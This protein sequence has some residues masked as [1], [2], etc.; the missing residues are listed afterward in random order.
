MPRP[1]VLP[2][3]LAAAIPIFAATATSAATRNEAVLAE[4]NFARMHPAQYG[5]ELEHAALRGG[6]E[7]L[8]EIGNEDVGAL[9]HALAF[10]ERQRPLPPLEESA[11][12]DAAARA[13]ALAQGR[14]HE[15]GHVSPDGATLS[16]RLHR[17]GVW[18]GLSGE[19]ISYGYQSP[20]D[21]VRQLI[22]DS[23]VPDRGHR[24]NIFGAHYRA[25]GVACAPHR[26]YGA[27]CVIEFAGALVKR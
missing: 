22:V 6:P 27:M 15:V 19:D 10:L 24:Q 20:R 12:L 4:I 3:A 13:H 21:I 9:A 26:E 17:H 1:C 18:S 16:D 2:A 7:G 14:T 8:S 23:G 11:G 5:R 25:V